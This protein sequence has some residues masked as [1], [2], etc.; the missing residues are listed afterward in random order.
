MPK[1]AKSSTTAKDKSVKNDSPEKGG[2]GIDKKGKKGDGK[3]QVEYSQPLI[4]KNSKVQFGEKLEAVKVQHKD[5]LEDLIME[6]DV[7]RKENERLR[8]QQEDTQGISMDTIDRMKKELER[9]RTTR[10]F[11]LEDIEIRKAKS[12]RLEAEIFEM[13]MKLESYM[14]QINEYS[15]QKDMWQ[16]TS[17]K[18]QQMEQKC[19]KLSKTNKNLRML[20]VKHHIDPKSVEF[21]SGKSKRS[22]HS[23]QAPVGPKGSIL[24]SGPKQKPNAH[25]MSHSVTHLN[26]ASRK[27]S[28]SLEDIRDEDEEEGANNVKRKMSFTSRKALGRGPPSYLGYYSDIHQNRIMARA[29]NQNNHLPKLIVA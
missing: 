25:Q 13:N 1:S 21:D 3:T 2:K 26:G 8:R 12:E 24:K 7:V 20:L 19:E 29:R 17:E 9:A 15:R 22:V 5:K 11:L 4:V 14:K 10:S 18:L 28:R 16:E 6:M 23:E 27:L